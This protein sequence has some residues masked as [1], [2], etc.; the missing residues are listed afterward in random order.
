[1]HYLLLLVIISTLH[2]FLTRT[3]SLKEFPL[4]WSIIHFSW[5]Y[6]RSKSISEN[7]P[8]NSRDAFFDG[9][10]FEYFNCRYKTGNLTKIETFEW[11]DFAVKVRFRHLIGEDRWGNINLR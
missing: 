7:F 5:L 10:P 4:D 9:L 11:V 6:I 3:Y 8:W 2:L 1:M